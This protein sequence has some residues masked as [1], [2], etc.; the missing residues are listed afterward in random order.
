MYSGQGK[1]AYLWSVTGD[2]LQSVALLEGLPHCKDVSASIQGNH[3]IF[4]YYKLTL[5][6][7]IGIDTDI[8]CIHWN[9]NFSIIFNYSQR[10]IR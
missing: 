7:N 6:I 8:T 5:K 3:F 9:V 10:E 2:S 1:N 4:L